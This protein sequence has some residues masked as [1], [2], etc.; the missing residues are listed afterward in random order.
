MKGIIL[1]GGAGSRLYPMT[2]VITKQLQPIYDK[3][4]IYYPLSLLMLG[5]IREIL[6]ITTSQDLPH[7]QNLLQD[8]KQLGIEITYEIQK[9]PKGLPEAFI[10]GKNFIGNEDVTLILGDNLF[11]GDMD[12]YRQALAAQKI[13]EF[14][15]DARIFA[16]SVSNPQEYGVVEFDKQTKKVLSIEEKPVTPKSNYSI[17]GLYLFD[18]SVS[19]RAFMLKP[20]P[21]GEL[22]ITDLIL[23]YHNDKKL[24]VEIIPRGVAWLDTGTPRTLLEASAY[25]GTIE[26]RQGLKVA[27][28][29]EI[30]LRMGFIDKGLLRTQI[31]L[32][33][34]GSYKAYIKKVLLEC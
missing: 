33:P 25:I 11:H 29:E 30:A 34:S 23:S 21:R 10:L 5:G 6:L 8:G 20:S 18:S 1:A 26:S 13:K 7:F 32:M 27:C 31:S 16:Y 2:K 24:G 22:E 12:F 3:P 9:E 15:L 4:M 14:G 17:P 19:E 28:L